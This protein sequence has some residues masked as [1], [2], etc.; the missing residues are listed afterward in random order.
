LRRINLPGRDGLAMTAAL[1]EACR[2]AWIV[3]TSADVRHV[4]A[5][6]LRGCSADAFVPK[7]DLATSAWVTV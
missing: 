5:E 6:I 4:A 2:S 1:S 3:L 7:E